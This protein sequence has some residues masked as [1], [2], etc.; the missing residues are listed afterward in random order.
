M[1]KIFIGL[2]AIIVSNQI[3]AVTEIT[4][5]NQNLQQLK[6]RYALDCSV[7]KAH[8]LSYIVADKS[9]TRMI[10]AK[11]RQGLFK[12]Q[13]NRQIAQQDGFKYL[14]S[15]SYDGFG[16]DFFTK[17]GQNWIKVKNTGLVNK[18]GPKT[19]AYLMQ[20]PTKKSFK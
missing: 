12:N 13:I 6:G 3:F 7:K 19:D 4:D 18:F 11:P 14:H 16:V 15:S 20:C 9:M 17:D 5:V 8:N 2:S 10:S 1:K